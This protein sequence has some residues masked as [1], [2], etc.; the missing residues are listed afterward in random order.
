MPGWTDLKLE[1]AVSWKVVWNVDP[2]PLSVPESLAPL[3]LDALLVAELLLLAGVDEEL[4]EEHAA[5]DRAVATAAAPTVAT[6]CLRPSGISATPYRFYMFP[7]PLRAAPTAGQRANRG[8]PV[9][10]AGAN[11]TRGQTDG[12]Q[13]WTRRL[14]SGVQGRGLPNGGVGPG[15]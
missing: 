5:R 12:G 13:M 2:L 4:D 10:F 7:R 8:V 11:G 6:R 9:Q 15:G 1:A 14:S 3:L